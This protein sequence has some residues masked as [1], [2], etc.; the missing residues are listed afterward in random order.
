MGGGRRNYFW[1][2]RRLGPRHLPRVASTIGICFIRVV[3]ET[4]NHF[5]YKVFVTATTISRNQRWAGWLSSLRGHSIVVRT[6]G[7]L[8]G[9]SWIW[10]R[11]VRTNSWAMRRL[12]V[13]ARSDRLKIA[14]AER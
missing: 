5:I 10:S 12:S 1:R 13:A 14:L 3:I 4:E 7:D 8:T 2:P 9:S 11:S 6:T